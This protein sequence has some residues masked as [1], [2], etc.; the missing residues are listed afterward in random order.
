[1]QI[2]RINPDDIFLVS[3]PKSGN[4][5]TRFVIAYMKAGMD[6]TITFHDLEHIVPDVYVAKDY[7]DSQKA[8][9]IIKAHHFF[10]D[11]YPNILY[12][13][14]DYRDVLVSFYNF[15]KA[16]KFFTGTFSTFIRSEE[17]LS[18]HGNWKEHVSR[19]LEYK[20]KNPEHCLLISYEQLSFNFRETALKIAVFCRLSTDI[21][22]DKLEQL[23]NFE[24]L[25]SD[26]DK[27]G[28][29]FKKNTN[30]NFMR[31]GK[32]GVWKN[33]FSTEDLEYLYSD[34][35]LVGLLQTLG[36]EC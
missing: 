13:Y 2:D 21:D 30:E 1:L 5:W 27:F 23:T 8:N 12:V 35:E 28:S 7:I 33:V 11:H 17:Y 10:P 4:T 36:Y 32:A 25:R 29:I 3:Y 31:E 15:Q 14:R 9:R 18:M 16:Y 34:K 19:A 24:K 20:K 22:L 26:E 6:H